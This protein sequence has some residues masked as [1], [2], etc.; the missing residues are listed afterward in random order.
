M[1]AKVLCELLNFLSEDRDLDLR[2]TGVR[3]VRLVLINQLLLLVLVEHRENV[4]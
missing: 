2:R 1:F 3:V 4:I